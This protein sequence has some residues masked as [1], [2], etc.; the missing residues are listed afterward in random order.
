[1]EVW[2]DVKDYE[3]LYQVSNLGNVKS[4]ERY[5]HTSNTRYNKHRLLR[6]RILKPGKNKDGYSVVV[7]RKDCKGKSYYIHRLVAEAFLPNPHNL[8]EINHKDENKENNHVDN[9]EWCT[10][11]YNG[12]Y[13]TINIRKR[14]QRLGFKHSEETR[15]RIS[16]IK[17]E[18][19]RT[20]KIIK[21]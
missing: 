21:V 5:A 19:W 1:M 6:E 18:W 8:P 3:G 13:G 7:L 14:N 11:I 10:H 20:H 2:K 15:Q 9:L 4:L 12:N 16:E 17:K